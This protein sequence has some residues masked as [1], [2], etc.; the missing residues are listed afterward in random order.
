MQIAVDVVSVDLRIK[1]K[2][3]LSFLQNL[4]LIVAILISG[5]TFWI[6]LERGAVM[7]D[8]NQNL[9]QKLPLNF[10]ARG[11]FT[12]E[13]WVSVVSIDAKSKTKPTIKKQG[14]KWLYKAWP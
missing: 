14:K 6:F 1:E 11:L 7:A 10:R 12:P 5:L 9:I 13:E 3:A 4:T 8:R 2:T